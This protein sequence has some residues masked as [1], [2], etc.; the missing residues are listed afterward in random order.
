MRSR[1][2]RFFSLLLQFPTANSCGVARIRDSV[3][4][5]PLAATLL[6]MLLYRCSFAAA[7]LL[8]SEVRQSRLATRRPPGSA[9]RATG[10]LFPANIFNKAQAGN[11]IVFLRVPAE[12]P[13][14]LQSPDPALLIQRRPN[15][16][17]ILMPPSNPTKMPAFGLPLS[18]PT[19]SCSQR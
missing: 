11:R 5:R 3:C 13:R 9:V 16:L 10:S 1:K 7:P 14:A 2:L 15:T 19:T 8:L 12:G 17:V 18:V 6:V 4:D